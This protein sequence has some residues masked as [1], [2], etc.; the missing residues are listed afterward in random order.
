MVKNLLQ[1]TMMLKLNL[2]F[3]T[4]IS[5]IDIRISSII[6]DLKPFLSAFEKK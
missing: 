4:I 1:L 5:V 2:K 3:K 6:N